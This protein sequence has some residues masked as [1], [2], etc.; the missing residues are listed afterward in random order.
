MDYDQEAVNETAANDLFDAPSSL[1]DKF[2][3]CSHLPKLKALESEQLLEFA[4]EDADFL[5]TRLPNI[6]TASISVLIAK[7]P[8]S[9]VINITSTP[10][11]LQKFSDE[12]IVEFAQN[13]RILTGTSESVLIDLV[14]SRPGIVSQLPMRVFEEFIRRKSFIQGLK[15]KTM[16]YLFMSDTLTERLLEL[17]HEALGR[18]S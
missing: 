14:D 4:T 12:Q 15:T 18:K 10:G 13:F 3:L 8:E 2:L 9:F 17:P 6:C 5:A 1:A 7:L 11:L 16:M